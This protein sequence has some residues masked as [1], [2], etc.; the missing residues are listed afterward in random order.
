MLNLLIIWQGNILE[1]E[2]SIVIMMRCGWLRVQG[3]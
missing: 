1:L 2:D 3:K